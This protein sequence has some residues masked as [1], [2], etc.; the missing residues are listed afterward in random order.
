[1]AYKDALTGVKSKQAWA[2]H[3]SSINRLIEADAANDFALLVCDINGL[4]YVNDHFGHKTGDEYIC[5][6]CQMVCTHYKHSP[7]YRVGGDEF[8]VLLEGQSFEEREE[9]LA[10]FNRKMEE[11]LKSGRVVVS[12]GMALY[13]PEVDTTVFDVFERADGMMYQRKYELKKMGSVMR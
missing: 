6:A 4:K 1:M 13:H 3:A 12:A 5:S 8:L 2:E 11:N 10:G 9:L 7:V